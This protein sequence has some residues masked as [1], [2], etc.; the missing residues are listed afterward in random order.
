MTYKIG[1]AVP[2]TAKGK[3]TT[4]NYNVLETDSEKKFIRAINTFATIPVNV[5]GGHRHQDNVTEIFGWLRFDLDEEGEEEQLESCLEQ[6]TYYKKPSTRN[7]EFSYKWH[8]FVPVENQSQNYDQ[9]KDQAEQFCVKHA[10]DFLKDMAVTKSVTQNMNPYRGD[11]KKAVALTTKH[12]G[13]ITI[14]RLPNPKVE[15]VDHEAPSSIMEQMKHSNDISLE[16]M[17]TMMSHI[18]IMDYDKDWNGWWHI[19]KALHSWAV[20]NPD[21]SLKQAK[22]I[23]LEWSSG[24]ENYADDVEAN[25]NERWGEICKDKPIANP[26]T[27]ATIIKKASGGGYIK[28]ASIQDRRGLEKYLSSIEEAQS[29]DEITA[30]FK[31]TEWQESKIG[32]QAETQKKLYTACKK[33]ANEIMK[34]NGIDKKYTVGD[35]KELVTKVHKNEFFEQLNSKGQPLPTLHNLI[36]FVE[37]IS[38]HEFEYDV[39]VKRPIINGNY[40]VKTLELTWAKAL[41]Q[42]E[43]ILHYAPPAMLTNNYHALFAS[44]TVNPLIEYVKGLPEWDGETDYIGKIAQSLKTKKAP[45]EYVKTCMRCFAIQAVAAWDNCTHTPHKLSKLES[46][47]TFVGG[48]GI[49]KTTWMGALMPDLMRNYFKEGIE[50]DPN[51]TD[52]IKEATSAGLVELGELDATTRKADISSLKSFLSKTTDEY[53]LPY[54]ESSERYPR[55]TVFTGTVNN[56]DFLK[57]AT[58]SRRFLAIDVVALTLPTPED[59]KG[60]WA[61]AYAL[62]ISGENWLLSF[63]DE[64]TQKE[65][66]ESFTDI[67]EIGDIGLQFL[68]AIKSS[69]E[70]KML[71]SVT[72]I[73]KEIVPKQKINPRERSDFMA[74]LAKAGHTRNSQGKFYLPSDCFDKYHHAELGI[75]DLDSEDLDDFL[76]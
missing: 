29:V 1:C 57:D 65:V 58:G 50:L 24:N 26:L 38:E 20:G 55:Q 9:F 59:V 6:F 13:V 48:Q 72:K 25:I 28:P 66:N 45:Y 40:S 60:M 67:G 11:I 46:V 76:N 21:I 63:A 39:I 37:N 73:F 5:E 47:L 64:E 10:I 19:G 61:Q 36:Y 74:M 2:E 3:A 33:R 30:I 42:D 17:K 54:G 51:N 16:E 35:F 49:G 7:D 52:S 4:F 8:Y 62:Y 15:A 56:N 68:S 18:D 14:A 75:H 41:L 31:T 43:L 12:E 32:Y 69:T 70:K 27:F 34:E 71:M 22:A 44:R 53:R 23:Y